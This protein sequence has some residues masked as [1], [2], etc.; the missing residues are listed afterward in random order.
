MCTLQH[1]S[2]QAQLHRDVI[3]WHRVQGL[4]PHVGFCV[5]HMPLT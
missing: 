1:M 5:L 4:G 3:M 2:I